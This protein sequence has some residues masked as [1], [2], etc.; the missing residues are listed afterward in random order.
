MSDAPDPAKD[1]EVFD[2]FKFRVVALGEAA[3][4][5]TS[6]L[7][8]YT[9]NAFNEE[10]KATI[11]TT[12]AS[13]DV[14]LEYEGGHSRKVRL[15]LWDMGG[16]ATYR[17]LRRQFMKGASGAIIAYDVTRPETYMA[18]N[19]WFSSFREVCPDAA[20]VICANKVDLEDQRMVPNQPGHMLRDWFQA[21]YFETSA[22]TGADVEKAFL[23]LARMIMDKVKEEGRG[24]TM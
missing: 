18:M 1:T 4:G 8:R 20:V 2:G 5:K 22:K 16:Q 10:Y 14:E 6:L 21:E 9:E 15:V 19:T 13:K 7:R 12:F 17:E 3:V 24:P 23:R 11:G